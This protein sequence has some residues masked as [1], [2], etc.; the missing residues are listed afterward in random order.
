MSFVL[1]K[2]G[3]C[4]PLTVKKWRSDRDSDPPCLHSLM[5]CIGAFIV[6]ITAAGLT[7][8]KWSRMLANGSEVLWRS[9][10]IQEF[11]GRVMLYWRSF[12]N[13]LRVISYKIQITWCK[14]AVQPVRVS[15]DAGLV[16]QQQCA[17]AEET[18]AS[19]SGS[20]HDS[21]H[22]S[23]NKIL[24]LYLKSFTHSLTMWKL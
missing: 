21:K 8:W 11:P 19:A 14:C 17:C 7:V 16:M 2:L 22:L 12:S 9:P 23:L 5:I 6:S 18:C 10:L 24:Q 15:N 3:W 4:F 20:S 1:R 13:C